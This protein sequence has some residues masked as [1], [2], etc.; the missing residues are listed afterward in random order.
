MR[1]PS[2][3]IPRSVAGPYVAQSRSPPRRALPSPRLSSLRP[4]H[5]RLPTLAQQLGGAA[6][7]RVAEGAGDAVTHQALHA[8]REQASM[9]EVSCAAVLSAKLTTLVGT[10]SAEDGRGGTRQR[11][12]AEPHITSQRPQCECRSALRNETSVRVSDVCP[13]RTWT[14][15][16]MRA[17]VECGSWIIEFSCV[18]SWPRHM[19]N[20]TAARSGSR[21]PGGG[22]SEKAPPP[23][24][25]PPAQMTTLPAGMTARTGLVRL[26][27]HAHFSI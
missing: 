25:T 13:A 20:S 17:T 14:S 3:K 5:E 7:V 10:R 11:S 2:G 22:R 23:C 18:R 4:R 16:G 15:T 19:L 1:H 24:Q 12:E 9:F 21:P 27:S 6:P 26:V 8:A